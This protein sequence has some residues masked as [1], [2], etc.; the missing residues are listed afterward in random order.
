LAD[1]A[2]R[3]ERVREFAGVSC[4]SPLD[5][6]QQLPEWSGYQRAL[7]RSTHLGRRHHLHRAGDLRGAADGFDAPADIRELA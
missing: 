2:N 4:S 1:F 3:Q 5:A 6:I 7:L